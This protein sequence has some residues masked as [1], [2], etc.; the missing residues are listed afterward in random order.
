MLLQGSI[1]KQPSV[2][3][4]EAS[5][6]HPDAGALLRAAL[7]AA[8]SVVVADAGEGQAAALEV[9]RH[10]LATLRLA[11]GEGPDWLQVAAVKCLQQSM[12]SGTEST[13]PGE[14]PNM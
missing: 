11:V 2:G 3:Q 12:Q 13:E 1:G 9:R 7:E 14:L 5:G 8:G 6:Q 4:C 10:A